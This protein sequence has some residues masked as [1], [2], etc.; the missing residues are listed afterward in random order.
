MDNG[1]RQQ[2]PTEVEASGAGWKAK[3]AGPAWAVIAIIAVLGM[4]WVASRSLDVAMK[5]IERQ[6]HLDAAAP[7]PPR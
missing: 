1:Q 6:Q 4:I 5:A 3:L 7:M 2:V